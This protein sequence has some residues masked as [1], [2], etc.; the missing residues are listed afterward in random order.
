METAAQ[1][2]A[3]E[4]ACETSEPGRLLG[5]GTEDDKGPIATALYAMLA[6]AVRGVPL[7]RRIELIVS[8]T[9]ESDWEPF[10]AFLAEKPPPEA[11]RRPD[12]GAGR[13]AS[14]LPAP[15]GGM[16]ESNPRPTVWKVGIRSPRPGSQGD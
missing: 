3:A 9:E 15:G 7:E 6:V 14:P 16:T 5:R 10:Q 2:K 11:S 8:Y 4:L 12:R 1:R 13:P